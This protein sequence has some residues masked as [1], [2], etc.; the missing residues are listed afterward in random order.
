MSANAKIVSLMLALAVAAAALRLATGPIVQLKDGDTLYA[1]AKSGPV[2]G[3]TAEPVELA[4][5]DA[6]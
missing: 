4:A 6:R 2:H 5:S 3:W 1:M